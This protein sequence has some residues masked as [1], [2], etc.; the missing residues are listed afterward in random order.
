MLLDAFQKGF[1]LNLPG[2]E[3]STIAYESF[4]FVYVYDK[5]NKLTSKLRL[6]DF[7]V[8]ERRYEPDTGVLHTSYNKMS[9]LSQ[10]VRLDQNRMLVEVFSRGGEGVTSN[11]ERSSYYILDPVR[12]QLH[13]MGDLAGSKGR[14]IFADH[15][16]LYV[17]EYSVRWLPYD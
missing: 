8:S 1:I 5:D 13:H 16:V 12:T 2:S 4:P 17:S 3:Y 10:M 11:F 14:L 7:L 9:L 15:G 6:P